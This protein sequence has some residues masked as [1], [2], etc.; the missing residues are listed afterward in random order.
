ME[1]LCSKMSK[2]QNQLSAFWEL[3]HWAS[4]LFRMLNTETVKN[5]VF[6]NEWVCDNLTGELEWGQVQSNTPGKGKCAT[7]N[8]EFSNEH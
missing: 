8:Q 3:G 7:P 1:I 2:M 6:N 5:D 4:I